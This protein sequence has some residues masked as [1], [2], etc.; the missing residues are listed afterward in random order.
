MAGGDAGGIARAA[1]LLAE[2]G[3]AVEADLQRYYG[4]HIGDFPWPLTARRLLTLIDHLPDDAA[5]RRDVLPEA[6]RP[7]TF[8]AMLLATVVD[9]LRFT[10]YQAAKIAGA[11][12]A[13]P[14]EPI[15]RPGVTPRSTHVRPAS[16][17]AAS[18]ALARRGIAI[19]DDL[20][21]GD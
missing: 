11:K 21:G 14:P 20:K 5:L 6:D 1:A 19:P 7:W 16:R 9:E 4:L 10:Q 15:T 8:E 18:A 12:R 3:G 2:H 13:T 17:E